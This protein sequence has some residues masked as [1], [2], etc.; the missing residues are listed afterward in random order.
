M[1][2]A[3]KKRARSVSPVPQS[4][5]QT[6][7]VRARSLSPVPTGKRLPKDVKDLH[8]ALLLHCLQNSKFGVR[9]AAAQ[10]NSENPLIEA[11]KV[12]AVTKNDV[13]RYGAKFL[14]RIAQDR[15]LNQLRM[16]VNEA[17]DACES[18]PGD[19]ALLQASAMATMLFEHHAVSRNT[20]GLCGLK[21]DVLG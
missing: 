19:G 3:T 7:P 9:K 8:R 10:A 17:R 16:R 15:D 14:K 2:T 18:K 13:Q 5:S 21:V 1:R 20:M 6:V 4:G 11:K 12:A